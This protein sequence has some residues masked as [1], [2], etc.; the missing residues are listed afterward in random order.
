MFLTILA[1]VFLSISISI[2]AFCTCVILFTVGVMK[3]IFEFM[4]YSLAILV[5]GLLMLV[6]AIFT[7]PLPPEEEQ[8]HN[9]AIATATAQAKNSPKQATIQ[10]M[11][12]QIV[13]DSGK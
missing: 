1:Y 6:S 9:A 13:K 11:I 2:A 3:G 4:T 5:F 12:T 10:A 8:L 7:H